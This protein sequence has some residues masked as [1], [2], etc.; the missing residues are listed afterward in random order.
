MLVFVVVVVFMKTRIV[1][2]TALYDYLK[3]C[4]EN[5]HKA[6]NKVDAQ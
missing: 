5:T 4:C 1:I 3:N 6:G 2:D